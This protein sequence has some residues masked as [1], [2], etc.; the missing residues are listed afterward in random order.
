MRKCDTLA[1]GPRSSMVEL[2]ICN[3]RVGGS[4]PSVGSRKINPSTIPGLKFGVCHSA[5]AQVEGSGLIL[6]GAFGPVLMARF[7]AAEVSTGLIQPGKPISLLY[8]PSPYRTKISLRLQSP[9]HLGRLDNYF[10]QMPFVCP[11]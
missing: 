11:L 7:G 3:Q 4:N 10:F 5:R 6:S 8:N 1:L 9:N 2:L